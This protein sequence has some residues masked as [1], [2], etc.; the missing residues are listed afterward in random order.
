MKLYVRIY[1]RNILEILAIEEHGCFL[2]KKRI[3]GTDRKRKITKKNQEKVKKM[4]MNL[5]KI[6]TVKGITM[7][8]E[9][10]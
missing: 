5:S 3:R 2:K 10:Q 6:G 1:I 7:T 8:T 4:E 9:S